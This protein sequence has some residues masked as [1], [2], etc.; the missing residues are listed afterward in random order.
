MEIP[1]EDRTIV[2]M[3]HLQCERG[4]PLRYGCQGDKEP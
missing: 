3:K 1:Q 4:G 2:G